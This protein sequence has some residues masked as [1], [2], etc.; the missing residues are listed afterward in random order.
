VALCES[1]GRLQF[2]AG[3]EKARGCF[4]ERRIVSN[5]S[6]P[7]VQL[8]SAPSLFPQADARPAVQDVREGALVFRKTTPSTV[9]MSVC[10]FAL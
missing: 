9:F 8:F 4:N 10:A 2:Y 5:E 6:P 3:P 7:S 1:R